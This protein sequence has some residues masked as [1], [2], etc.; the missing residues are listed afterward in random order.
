MLGCP[1]YC[2]ETWKQNKKPK[3]N[4]HTIIKYRRKI[5]NQ[6]KIKAMGNITPTMDNYPR[7]GRMGDTDP[8]SD[9]SC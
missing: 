1:H 6:R 2:Q 3:I 8:Q 9:I 7:D 4:Q 5:K